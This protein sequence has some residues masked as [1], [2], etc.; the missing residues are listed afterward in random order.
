M[1]KLHANTVEIEPGQYPKARGSALIDL[2]N[3]NDVRLTIRIEVYRGK[4]Y[5]GKKSF[6]QGRI[7]IGRSLEADLVLSD[8]QIADQ[9]AC[10]SFLDGQPVIF[11]RTQEAGLLVGGSLCGIAIIASSENVGIGPYLL[12]ISCHKKEA[13]HNSSQRI[14]IDDY[15]NKYK[16]ISSETDV[17]DSPENTPDESSEPEQQDVD[18]PE[19]EEPEVDLFGLFEGSNVEE[20]DLYDLVFEGR[21]RAGLDMDEVKLNLS[22]I[23]KLDISQIDLFFSRKRIVLKSGLKTDIAVKYKKAFEKSGAL[24]RLAAHKKTEEHALPVPEEPENIPGKIEEDTID[25]ENGA[26]DD[27]FEDAPDN[28]SAAPFEEPEYSDEAGQPGAPS[29]EEKAVWKFYGADVDEEDDEDDEDLP[30]NFYLKERINDQNASGLS[31]NPK[32]G[33]YLEIIKFSAEDVVDIQY[34][35]ERDR[36]HIPDDEDK[37]FCLAEFRSAGEAFFCFS[38]K[39]QGKIAAE[40]GSPVETGLLMKD[41]NCINKR[42]KIYRTRVPEKGKV[43][44]SDG[45]FEYQL[46][47]VSRSL[48]PEI[49]EIKKSRRGSCRHLGVSLVFHIVFFAFLGLFP[50]FQ[51]EKTEEEPRFVKLDSNQIAEL[52]KMAKPQPKPEPPAPAPVVETKPAKVVKPRV[53]KNEPVRRA[54][55]KKPSKAKAASGPD[56]HPD[57]G[58]GFGKGNVETRNINET[59]IL[60]MIGDSVG[61]QPKAALAAVTNLDAVS[62]PNVTSGNLKVGGVVGKLGTGEIAVPKGS[63]VSTKGSSQVLRSHGR[64]GEG[65]VAALEKGTTG[66]QEVMGMVTATLDKTAR[67][68]GGLSMDAVKRVIDQHLDDITYCYETE[69]ISNPSIVGKVMFEWKILMSGE[70]GEVRI[71]SSSINSHE[72]HACIKD[73]IRTWR[74][75]KPRGSEVV[76]SYPFVFDIVGF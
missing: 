59:G 24:C 36:F 49:P 23:L 8:E 46:R 14:S 12:K 57:A 11:D 3:E 38:K 13:D 26:K 70:V 20:P 43:V 31:Q 74:F 35:D 68:R 45:Y 42:K 29:I 53:A 4:E 40:G 65:R 27:I 62:S 67:I 64:R 30:A 16:K 18:P 54:S 50:S 17:P 1:N 72:I 52:E 73:A 56:R 9:H 63:I 75:P 10:I 21:I 7:V 47:I 34:L 60:S 69:L 28:T 32:N 66:E 48:V 6:S 5:I 2:S 55:K 39:L 51:N 71:K 33:K 25:P 22:A 44:L 61:I 76:V 58:G 15:L 41:E 37:R 19:N